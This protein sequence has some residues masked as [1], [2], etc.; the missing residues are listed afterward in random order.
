MKATEIL[1]EEHQVIEQVLDCLEALASQT[2]KSG[3]LDA[4]PAQQAVDFLRNFADRCHHGKEE[5]QF[6]P[7]LE[8]RGFS[9]DCGPTAVMR[10][11]HEQGRACV[12]GMGEAVAAAPHDAAAAKRFAAHAREYVALLRGHIQK[13][14]NC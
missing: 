8:Q 6:F 4:L 5:A 10:L 2:E 1:K 3:K 9:K 14:N 12:K 11:E 13:E 7:L